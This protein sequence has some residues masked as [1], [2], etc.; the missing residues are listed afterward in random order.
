MVDDAGLFLGAALVT[1]SAL[2]DLVSAEWLAKLVLRCRAADAPVLFALTYD[3]RIECRPQDQDDEEIRRLVNA[4]QRRDKGFGPALGPEAAA[5]AVAMLTAAGYTT[6][7][8]RSDWELRPD[9]RDLQRE[10]VN[11][12]A[13]AALEM[14]PEKQAIIE[15]W[16]SRRLAH[17]DAGRSRMLVGHVDVAGICRP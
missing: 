2:L 11:G 8:E 6:K 16:R 5:K 7:Q 1:A 14:A 10:L 13:I 15:S 17:I 3:G 4:H 9:A 12:W